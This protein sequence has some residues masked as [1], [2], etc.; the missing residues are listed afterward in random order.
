MSSAANAVVASRQSRVTRKRLWCDRLACG[1][2]I[3]TLP[4]GTMLL[5]TRKRRHTPH[6]CFN[7]DLRFNAFAPPRKRN[8]TSGGPRK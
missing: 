2:I 4:D 5:C 1:H 8:A 3:A 6:P 7:P